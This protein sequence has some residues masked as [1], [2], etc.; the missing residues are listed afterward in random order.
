MF[1]FCLLC[2]SFLV[3]NVVIPEH[4]SC[5]LPKREICFYRVIALSENLFTILDIIQKNLNRTAKLRNIYGNN[6]QFQN[7]FRVKAKFRQRL[8]KH[9]PHLLK[10][11]FV[12]LS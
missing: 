5:F 3:G 7:I 10:F 4:I 9:F 11:V 1:C 12:S 6:Q 2:V 8:N